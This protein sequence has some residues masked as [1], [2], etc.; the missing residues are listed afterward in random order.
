MPC[1][2]ILYHTFFD[3]RTFAGFICKSDI[4]CF[5]T[6]PMNQYK[7]IKTGVNL[8]INQTQLIIATNKLDNILE[9]G[10]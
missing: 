1:I 5:F 3:I 8:L 2:K 9:I 10:N 7:P 4:T 6:E